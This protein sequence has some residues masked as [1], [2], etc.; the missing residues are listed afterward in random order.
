MEVRRTDIVLQGN[1]S[2]QH[3]ATMH[4]TDGCQNIMFNQS[5]RFV[6]LLYQKQNYS[7]RCIKHQYRFKKSLT[8]NNTMAKRKGTKE[9]TT[10]YKTLHRKLNIEKHEPH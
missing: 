8:D 1:R 6:N 5:V 9:H 10:I 4:P 2:R 3:N 7:M